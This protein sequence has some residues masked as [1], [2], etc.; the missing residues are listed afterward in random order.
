ML[1]ELGYLSNADEAS[2]LDTPAYHRQLAEAIADGVVDYLQ[3]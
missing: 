1:V 2:R 3:R